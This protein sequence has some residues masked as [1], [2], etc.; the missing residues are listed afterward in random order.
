MKET[1]E[2]KYDKK[3]PVFSAGGIFTAEDV[4]RQ[5]ALGCDGVQV[6][7]RFVATEECDASPEYKRAYIE[8]GTED[9][10][11]IKSPVGRTGAAQFLYRESSGW[12]RKDYGLF[13][14]SEGL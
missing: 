5:I 8:A 7:S 9:I 10:E 3:I 6:A 13:Q 1:F 4:R 2:E 11:I 12:K 14:L